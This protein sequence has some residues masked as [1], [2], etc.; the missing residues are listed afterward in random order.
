MY[1]CGDKDKKHELELEV[2][3]TSNKVRL[4]CAI[5]LLPLDLGSLLVTGTYF[6]SAEM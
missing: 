3:V 2:T 5:Y 6:S 1:F 4:L